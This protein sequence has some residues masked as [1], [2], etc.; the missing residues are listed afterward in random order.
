MIKLWM[1]LV[2]ASYVVVEYTNVV[3]ERRL[4]ESLK[5]IERSESGNI[6]DARAWI[7]DFKIRNTE[8]IKNASSVSHDHEKHDEL[9]GKIENMALNEEG[10]R[11]HAIRLFHFYSHTATCA[12]THVCDRD[13][14]CVHFAESI[15][16]DYMMFADLVDLWERTSFRKGLAIVDVFLDKCAEIER[17]RPAI[18]LLD[19]GMP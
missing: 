11:S 3:T 1:T 14:L 19:S 2:A 4:K 18:T 17:K 10:A 5:Y 8:N 7:A 12:E 6:A 9:W 13:I 15:G 16:E